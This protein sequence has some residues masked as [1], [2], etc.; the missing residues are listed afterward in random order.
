MSRLRPILWL[1]MALPIGVS[2]GFVAVAL[3]NALARAGVAESVT[4][5]IL[6]TFYLA[7]S[8]GVLWGPAIDAIFSRR[9]WV[10][11]GLLVTAGGLFTLTIVPSTLAGANLLS[12]IA[13]LTGS[14]AIIVGLSSKGI[15]AY[16]F[17][18][19]QRALA[20]AWYA[21]GNLGSSSIAGAVG[22]SLLASK[23][24]R[25]LVA[26]I[27]AASVLITMAFV[28]W[29]PRES[30]QPTK[31]AFHRLVASLSDIWAMIRGAKGKVALALCVLPFAERGAA[32][33]SRT[34][35]CFHRV[36]NISASLRA[37]SPSRRLDLRAARCLESVCAARHRSRSHVARRDTVGPFGA[38]VFGDLQRVRPRAR[39]DL[40]RVL[41]GCF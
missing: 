16:V 27:V 3:A 4:A 21:A 40:H 24:S 34:R 23:Q 14:G 18:M 10:I 25:S 31:G 7:L 20:G 13:F 19:K 8:F 17:P 2:T 32:M 35:Y 36:G 29:L 12:V 28:A 11:F 38:L 26:C 5:D 37:R 33:E 9:L 41:R 39:R 22:V 15:A 1:P 6:A 30:I